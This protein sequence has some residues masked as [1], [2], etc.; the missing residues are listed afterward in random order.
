MVP[1]EYLGRDGSS[2]AQEG[3]IL[4]LDDAISPSFVGAVRWPG[5]LDELVQVR[6]FPDASQVTSIQVCHGAVIVLSVTQVHNP[7]KCLPVLQGPFVQV[8]LQSLAFAEKDSA[9]LAPVPERKRL[10]PEQ[11]RFVESGLVADHSGEERPEI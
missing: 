7:G 11:S 2:G 3:S 5:R 1:T 8:V 6:V 4:I 9:V 10:H